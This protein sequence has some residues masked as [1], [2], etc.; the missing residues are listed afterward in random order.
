[1]KLGVLKTL[2]GEQM[3]K[4]GCHLDAGLRGLK[5]ENHGDRGWESEQLVT[6]WP[7]AELPL[8]VV[9][10]RCGEEGLEQSSSSPQTLLAFQLGPDGVSAAR[11]CVSEPNQ[12]CHW[13]SRLWGFVDSN[14][15]VVKSFLLNFKSIQNEN[16]GKIWFLLSYDTCSPVCVLIH[17]FIHSSSMC[18]ISAKCQSTI[19]ACGH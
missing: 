7:G 9:P 15:S 14:C 4:T 18:W 10:E 8:A 6:P 16:V 12:V 2:Y 17:S 11:F 5:H 1:M 13:L 19:V 3:Y